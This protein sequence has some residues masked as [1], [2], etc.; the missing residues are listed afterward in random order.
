MA[1]F[2]EKGKNLS[3]LSSR[4]SIGVSNE[5]LQLCHPCTGCHMSVTGPRTVVGCVDNSITPKQD[6][7]SERSATPAVNFGDTQ[8]QEQKQLLP[9]T[10]EMRLDTDKLAPCQPLSQ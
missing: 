2:G 7:R 5:D 6:T 4:S 8:L 3:E 9:F 1:A 10:A